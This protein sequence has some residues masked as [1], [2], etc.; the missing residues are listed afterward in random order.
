MA[1][2]AA[3]VRD[4][5]VARVTTSEETNCWVWDAPEASGYGRIWTGSRADGT[6]RI[7]LAHVVSY[8]EHVGPVPEGLVLDHLCRNRACINPDHLEPVTQRVNVLRGEGRA[9]HQAQQTHCKRGHEFDEQNTYR[10]RHGKR[11]CRT[12]IGRPRKV[13]R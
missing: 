12:C 10:D 11:Y 13:A 7:R 4:R 8:E 6:R 9:A 5:L 2:Q 3:P 1:K